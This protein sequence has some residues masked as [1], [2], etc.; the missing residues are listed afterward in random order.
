MRINGFKHRTL[1]LCII[2]VITVTGILAGGCYSESGQTSVLATQD[3]YTALL[4]PDTNLDVYI[5]AR[6]EGLTRI[7]SE[8]IGMSSDIDVESLTIWGIP[9]D[10]RLTFGMCL[11]LANA[12]TA[13]MVI[14]KIAE[15]KDSWKILRDNKIY[16]VQGS[17]SSAEAMKM[18]ILNNDF[19]YY[20]D[21]QIIEL[22]ATM[23]NRGSAKLVTILV[24]KPTKELMNY[25]LEIN[26]IDEIKQVM[27][28][29]NA[30]DAEVVV[31]G[32]YS[33]YRIN[34]AKASDVLQKGDIEALELG[35]LILIKSGLPGFIAGPIIN[36][37]LLDQGFVKQE[38]ENVTI[39]RGVFSLSNGGELPVFIRIKDS[40]IIISASGREAYSETL[41]GSIYK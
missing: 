6:Q 25:L 9:E 4:V 5:Y 16:I 30:I 35:L 1:T 29:V 33:P 37:V 17:G 3:Q 14:S 10:E 27:S 11:V 21:R 32:L 12:N 19:K 39:Y 40:Y 2:S 24:A 13:S 15:K 26:V 22:V 28:L 8:L 31:S 18:A 38:N 34:I 36:N 20:D 7:P 23:P 41:I